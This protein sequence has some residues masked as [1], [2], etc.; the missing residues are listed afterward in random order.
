M[1]MPGNE[2]HMDLINPYGEDSGKWNHGL[3]P[4]KTLIDFKSVRV[5]KII[6]IVS[7]LTKNT[8]KE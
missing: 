7:E 1:T 6:R 4:F 3:D 8:K 2:M 5:F